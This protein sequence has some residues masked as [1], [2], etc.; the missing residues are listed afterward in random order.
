M[1]KA[2]VLSAALALL[3]GPALAQ[4]SGQSASG[5]LGSY[6]RKGGYYGGWGYAPYGYGYGPYYGAYAA[7]PVYS[8]GGPAY[9]GGYYPAYYGGY[10]G[11]YPGYY[12]GGAVAAGIIGG[13]ALSALAAPRYRYHRRVYR[14]W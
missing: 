5:P 11:Y 12:D 10:G 4:F 7:A 8:Y 2:L 6:A 1:K 3:S 9:Y 14:R 13:I